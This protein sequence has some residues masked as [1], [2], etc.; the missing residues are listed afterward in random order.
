MYWRL[1]D[2]QLDWAPF[3]KSVDVPQEMSEVLSLTVVPKS[4]MNA[5][6]PVGITSKSVAVETGVDYL[7]MVTMLRMNLSLLEYIQSM[8][9]S[10]HGLQSMMVSTHG[11]QSMMVSTHGLSPVKLESTK[12]YVIRLKNKLENPPPWI[13]HR[14]VVKLNLVRMINSHSFEQINLE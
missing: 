6:S 10:T 9:V 12:I 2:R 1:Y 11:L 3:L 13:P 7:R 4:T 14:K 5:P 8:M